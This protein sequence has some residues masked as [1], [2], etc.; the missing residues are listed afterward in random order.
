M[1]H[2][3]TFFQKNVRRSTSHQSISDA[4]DD[5]TVLPSHARVL[6]LQRLIGNQRTRQ[7]LGKNTPPTG[8]LQRQT[9]PQNTNSFASETADQKAIRLNTIQKARTKINQ[10]TM[11]IGGGFLYNFEHLNATQTGVDQSEAPLLSLNLKSEETFAQREYRLQEIIRM[12][13]FII[14]QLETQPIAPDAL[15]GENSA[16]TWEE[17]PTSYRGSATELSIA[18]GG[19]AEFSALSMLSPIARM[20]TIVGQYYDGPVGH[21]GDLLT[22]NDPLEILYLQQL[23]MQ[24]VNVKDA[25]LSLDYLRGQPVTTRRVPRGRIDQA[26]PL[27]MNIFVPDP[28]NQPLV[29]QRVRGNTPQGT[30]ADTQSTVFEIWHDANGYFYMNK[31]LRHYLP[32][33]VPGQ[34]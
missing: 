19:V 20:L 34:P 5:S 24:G 8:Q 26:R 12:L 9:A 28:E 31:G 16:F 7:T 2:R 27:G 21:Y 22:L 33:Y 4:D 10:L 23:Q 15:T 14:T 1:N 17:L 3:R 32:D 18:A 6:Q 13:I 25:Y 11:M 29:Y 30:Q